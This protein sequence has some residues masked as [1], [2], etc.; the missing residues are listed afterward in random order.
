M[1]IISFETLPSTQKYLINA[2]K[3]K[4]LKSPVCIIADIQTDGIGSRDN[5]WVFTK[6]SLFAS[7]SL[8]RGM[9]PD[10]LPIQ[11]ASIYFGQIMQE[12]LVKLNKNVWLK[13]PNDLYLSDKK[14]GGIITNIVDDSLVCGV[15]LNMGSNNTDFSSL[16]ID[17]TPYF[18][19]ESFLELVEKKPTW[20]QT[21][22]NVRIEFSKNKN[23][24]A[25]TLFGKKSL[26]SAVLC[27][28]GSLVIDG[29]RVYSL[30]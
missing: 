24:F 12:V 21:L 5:N 14:I 25:H 11:S 30:R 13:W 22:S 17:E 23:Y 8:P 19:L 1:E 9:F 16:I 18:I 7:I 6:G 28:D 15:G 2:I 3:D 10:D 27:D 4:L 20:K 26:E 29:E